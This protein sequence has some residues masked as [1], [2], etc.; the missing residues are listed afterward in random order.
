M[1]GVILAGG[2]GSRLYPITKVTNKCL[3]PVGDQP[4]IFRMIDIF[5]K[6]GIYDIMLVT[7]PDHMGHVI[8]LLG[9]GT[10]YGCE[11]T[12]RVQDEANG[13]AAA[14]KLCENFCN[15]EKFAVVL[16][17]NIFSDHY[18]ISEA[19]REFQTSRDDYCLFVKEV[20]DP[21]RFGVPIFDSG[22]IVDIVEKPE[23]PPSD[24][25]VVGLYCYSSDVF[26]AIKDL[27]K[28]KRGEYEISDVNSWYIKNKN[29]RF[30]DLKCK[31]VDAGTHDSF[32]RANEM[33]WSLK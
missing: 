20:E 26:S 30:V 8:S 9:S 25:A 21:H 16:G 6:S 17:D 15:K 27:K 4:M 10:E 22:K 23:N 1:K 12:Y 11:L 5:R 28:S 32:R 2:T 13:I 31:W 19:I 24:R 29:G 14:L 33:L 7:G 18:E 3:L